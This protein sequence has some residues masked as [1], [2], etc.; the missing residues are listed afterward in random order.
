M[1]VYVRERERERERER[2][3]QVADGCRI[4]ECLASLKCILRLCCKNSGKES[5]VIKIALLIT[6]VTINNI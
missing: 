2:A 3:N 6:T 1:C 5:D 4:S